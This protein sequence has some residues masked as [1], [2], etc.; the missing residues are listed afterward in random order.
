M[1][2]K[3]QNQIPEK[4]SKFK[5]F[6]LK[7]KEKIANLFSKDKKVTSVETQLSEYEL[8]YNLA[9]V[10]NS[11][12]KFK[13]EDVIK[14]ITKEKQDYQTILDAILS[15][16]YARDYEVLGF[17][18]SKL[19][20]KEKIFSKLTEDEKVIVYMFAILYS[21]KNKDIKTLKELRKEAKEYSE[22]SLYPFVKNTKKI[23]Y[24]E[25]T[26][27]FKNMKKF[28]KVYLKSIKDKLEFTL[29]D[30]ALT[31]YLYRELGQAN[32]KLLNK[33]YQ[34]NTSKYDALQINDLLCIKNYLVRGYMH[35][36]KFKKASE[37]IDEILQKDLENYD[38]KEAQMF[39][40]SKC[41]TIGEFINKKDINENENFL[42][43]QTKANETK[44]DIYLFGIN[45]IINEFTRQKQEQKETR[46]R[47]I[48]KLVAGG[49]CGLSVI[50]LIV[51]MLVDSTVFNVLIIIFMSIYMLSTLIRYNLISY[52]K[53]NPKNFI[54]ST[55]IRVVVGS[56]IIVLSY[57][58]PNVIKSI[59]DAIF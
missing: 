28:S 53:S 38:A 13:S 47:N 16:Q 19:S 22:N 14:V 12:Q 59:I 42:A 2:E 31:K 30:I 8:N 57:V 1:N 17:I 43:L 25:E 51:G 10:L 33:I 35:I 3:E 55:V 50:L 4:E 40:S 49:S 41:T 39:I 45:N 18:L 27:M 5:N 26:S 58:M 36:H 11:S 56:A 37:I 44:D 7:V 9:R 21:E 34:K 15:S 46:A 52:I 29:I 32:V 6:L 54:I 48:R 24:D 23:Y 20:E